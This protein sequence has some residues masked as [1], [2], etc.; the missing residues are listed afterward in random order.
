MKILVNILDALRT[1]GSPTQKSALRRQDAQLEGKQ[2]LDR[3]RVQLR[4]ELG[5]AESFVARVCPTKEV[6]VPLSEEEL[7]PIRKNSAHA[8]AF[9][10]SY[11]ERDVSSWSLDDLDAVFAAW[12]NADDKRGF[13][14]DKVVQIFGAAFGERCAQ[15]LNMRWVWIEDSDG[16]CIA[17]QGVDKDFR[18][19]PFH[20]VEKRV[21]GSEYGFFKSVFISL[22]SASHN[23]EVASTGEVNPLP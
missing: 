23:S 5:A 19:F 15:D 22:Q 9:L 4:T 11:L 2:V 7:G 16:K 17:L 10:A 13:Q 18:A 3:A 21:T 20:S 1:L 6:V 8:S 12:I 14:P